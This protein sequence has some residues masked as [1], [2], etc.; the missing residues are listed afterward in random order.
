MRSD[1]KIVEPKLEKALSAPAVYSA[2]WSWDGHHGLSS[3]KSWPRSDR[4][5]SWR[6]GGYQSND[7]DQLHSLCYGKTFSGRSLL[8]Y[9]GW[10]PDAE[11]RAYTIAF[12]HDVLISEIADEGKKEKRYIAP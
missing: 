12:Y 5:Y 8:V 10:I 11:M 6:L 3:I 2:S 4:G 7:G 1:L 9:E